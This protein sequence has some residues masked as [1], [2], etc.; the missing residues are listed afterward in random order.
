MSAMYRYGKV[1]VALCSN[2]S[3]ML[4]VWGEGER[5]CRIIKVGSLLYL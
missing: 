1:Y 5:G 3:L 2:M 4:L